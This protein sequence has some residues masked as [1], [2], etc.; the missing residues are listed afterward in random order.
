MCPGCL[1]LRRVRHD[2]NHDCVSG[3]ID[4]RSKSV[5]NNIVKVWQTD[6]VVLVKGEWGGGHS[7]VT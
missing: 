2:I 3:V 6:G 4:N 1:R 7:S 5:V